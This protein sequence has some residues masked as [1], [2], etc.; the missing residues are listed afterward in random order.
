MRMRK[1]VLAAVA[2]TAALV[3]PTTV[4]AGWA[5]STGATA[6]SA[7]ASA[8]PGGSLWNVGNAPACR[9]VG[10]PPEAPVGRAPIL[11]GAP[12]HPDQWCW[13]YARLAAGGVV[14]LPGGVPGER[15]TP[16]A[17]ARETGQAV[18]VVYQPSGGA[19]VY[20]SS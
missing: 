3:A 2:V 9:T 5:G 16:A 19:V 11:V 20:L 8:L 17:Y 10:G 1:H 18:T 7:D 15:L 14:L 12:G 13:A 4:L 6:L